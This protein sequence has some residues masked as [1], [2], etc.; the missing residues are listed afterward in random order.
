[1]RYRGQRTGEK[2]I[3]HPKKELDLNNYQNHAIT[4]EDFIIAMGIDVYEYENIFKNLI[5]KENHFIKK[6]LDNKEQYDYLH[7]IIYTLATYGF[8]FIDISY[9]FMDKVSH[10]SIGKLARNYQNK[11]FMQKPIQV[12]IPRNQE[13]IP[14][15][16]SWAEVL[17][18]HTVKDLITIMLEHK[19]YL[20]H[21]HK[22]KFL[23]IKNAKNLKRES[24]KK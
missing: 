1:M 4:F 24:R 19:I 15:Y 23:S 5:I 7:Y 13:H 16:Q 18:A 10:T 2:K 17:N 3:T 14:E 20:W 6:K 9:F 8:R 21:I 11:P 12:E 22:Q